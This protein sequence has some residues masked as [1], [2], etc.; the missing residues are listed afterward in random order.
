MRGKETCAKSVLEKS[1][2][3]FGAQFQNHLLWQ[4]LLVWSLPKKREEIACICTHYFCPYISCKFALHHIYILHITHIHTYV[5]YI[6]HIHA[7][8]CTYSTS[9]MCLYILN[10]Q[11][12]VI[13]CALQY[14]AV[15]CSVCYSVVQC[16]A[17]CCHVFQ[18][19]VTCCSAL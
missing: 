2:S 14:A 1:G 5:L 13:V 8:V 7:R 12:H 19:I 10:S 18:C 4:Q 6:L 16:G 11:C 17:V 9:S 15:Y 3:C